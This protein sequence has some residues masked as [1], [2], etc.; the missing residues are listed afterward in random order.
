MAEGLGATVAPPR[1]PPLPWG[2]LAEQLG[3]AG[4]R[5]AV[6]PACGHLSHEEA[7][8]ELLD[9]LQSFLLEQGLGRPQL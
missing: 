8:Q 4:P 2:R 9:F 7:P 3:A 1:L 6:L 5:L